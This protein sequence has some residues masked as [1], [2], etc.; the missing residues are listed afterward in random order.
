MF[1]FFFLINKENDKSAMIFTPSS[2]KINVTIYVIDGFFFY[3]YF[4]YESVI[5][6]LPNK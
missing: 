4:F 6:E 1:F 5:G 3:Y 2:L